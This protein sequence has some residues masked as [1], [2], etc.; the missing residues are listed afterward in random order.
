MSVS[1]EGRVRLVCVCVFASVRRVACQAVGMS[2][3]HSRSLAVSKF[4]QDRLRSARRLGSITLTSSMSSIL[5]IRLIPKGQVVLVT[6]I[7]KQE[8]VSIWGN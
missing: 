8:G 2:S 7:W 6:T 4:T 5:G 1:K 3:S